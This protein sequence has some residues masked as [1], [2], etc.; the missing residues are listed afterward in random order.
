LTAAAAVVLLAVGG[1]AAVAVE[2]GA[3]ADETTVSADTARTGWDQNEPALAPSQVTSAN[4]GQL[5]STAVDGQ[6]YAQPIV[7]G[8]TVIVAT[9]NNHVYGL[10][11]VTGAVKW[12]VSLGPAWP[13]SAIG[14][15]DLAPNV[16]VTSTPVYDPGTG[17]VYLTA[18]VN[19]G[20]DA[21]HPHYYMHALD[22]A[23]GAEAPGWPVT[24]GGT[25]SN[26]PGYAFNAYT[27]L[28]RPGLLLLD[29]T[30]YAAFSGHCDLGEYAGFVVGVKTSTQAQSV[31]IDEPL[32][33]SG[34]AG[35]WQSGSGLVSDGP[36][37]VFLVTGNGVSPGTGPG[38]SPPA[39]L[40]E[41][42]VRLG[43]AADG[44][45]SAQDYFSPANAA[46]LDTNDQDL[47]SGGPVSLPGS[48]GTPA[49]PHLMVQAGKD[50]RVFL[51]NRDDLGGSGQ[52]GGGNAVLGMTGPV[53]GVW[54][55]PAVWGG[56]GGYLYLD[57]S[58]GPLRALQ[59]GVTGDGT[60]ALSL[61]GNSDQYFSYTS[62]SPVV[63]SSGTTSGSAVVWVV[64]VTSGSGAGGEL[65]AFNALPVSGKLRLLRSFPIG[66]GAKFSVPAT[67]S[68][69]VYVG[70]RDGHVFG[71]GAPVPAPLTSAPVDFGPVNVG[72]SASATVTM[73]A[74]TTVTVSA[75]SVPAPF[76]VSPGALPV[77]LTAGQAL[78]LPVTF[79]PTA[80]GAAIGALS[81]TTDSGPVTA[82]LNG[83]GAE[84]GF[85][86]ALSKVSFGTVPV[87]LSKTLSVSF[88]NTGTTPETVSGVTPPSGAFTASGMP[89]I[90]ATVNPGVSVVVPVTY[91][92]TAA[93]ADSSAIAVTGPDGTATVTLTGT[94]VAGTGQVTMS[95]MSLSFGQVTVGKTVSKTFTVANTGNLPLTI[96]KAA[97][98]AAPFIVPSPISE[99]LAMSPGTSVTTTVTFTPTAAGSFTDTYEVSTDTG[100]GAMEV[101]LD[102]TAVSPA[103]SP[104][105]RTLAAPGGPGWKYNG[106][107]AMHGKDLVLTLAAKS[108][109]GTAF[110]TTA[111]PTAQLNATFTAKI[112]G[113]TGGD[114]ECF[115]ILDAAKAKP[116]AAGE[117]G[118]ALGFKDLPG[119]G[120]CL[121][122]V[123]T[124]GAPSGN[125]VGISTGG[126]SG[127]LVY[128]AAAKAIAALR[129]G[130]H[131]V[132]VKVSTPGHLV[133]TVDGKKI[134]STAVKIPA[135][136]YAGFSGATGSL[137][138]IH[139]VRAVKITY[140]S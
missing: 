70:T 52:S 105:T 104:V 49:Y 109:T 90:G 3:H 43:V 127:R 106:A 101:A 129:A 86:A 126:T 79:S 55:H 89:A 119:V 120:V 19:D 116:A 66:A 72:G 13:A 108:R 40:A 10:N 16:G 100:Q 114:G 99:G 34:G 2:A 71:F 122:T 26:D 29:G 118:A 138:D 124:S 59:Y 96:T 1:G 84:A 113:G 54:G 32:P 102:G 31:W 88:T 38:S 82:G 60:P 74:T 115:V 112:G 80:A 69:R 18:K 7:V 56:D 121:Q 15:G 4:F 65:L 125:F 39:Q 140:S 85:H 95:P 42:V 103:A 97:L 41:S 132:N 93:A 50:G 68:G 5:F 111:V 67:D 75:V 57:G 61:A 117:G 33:G 12:N 22:P 44:T 139:L 24:I 77:T 83:T 51:L 73:T 11:S 63:T 134:L 45:L 48:F 25:P 133:V 17:A 137:T 64:Q 107:A 128:L 76:T 36:G 23:T 20:A 131:L 8:S 27:Q 30:V 9:E 58:G 91:T 87:G 92:P 98:P 62:G 53:E 47:G 6:V 110:D 136:A 135:T 37:R 94:A 81:V 78:T 46:A 130:T 14:C 28:Q 123:K 21:Q 35:I